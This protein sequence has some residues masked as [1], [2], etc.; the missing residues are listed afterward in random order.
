MRRMLHLLVVIAVLMC[1]LHIGEP[2]FAY[3]EADHHQIGQ[4][5]GQTSDSDEGSPKDSG[6]VGPSGHHHCPMTPD[7]RDMAALSGITPAEALL[8]AHPVDI[9]H[10]LSQAPPVDPPS[11]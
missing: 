6:N 5:A 7:P 9:L 4:D 2:A 3:D 10:S 8:F 1:G 11:A